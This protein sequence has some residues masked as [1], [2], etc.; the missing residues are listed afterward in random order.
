[1]SG[2]KWGHIGSWVLWILAIGLGARFVLPLAL[3]FVLGGIL[4]L[5]AEPG[6]RLLQ[7]RFHWSRLP[8]VGVCVS[9]TLALTAALVSI[10]GAA[11]VRELSTVARLAP[12]VGKTVAQGLVV[13]EDWLVNLADSAPEEIRPL[14]IQTVL[15][16][17]HS[18]TAL[19]QQ[20]TG[21]IPGAVAGAVGMVSRGTLTAGTGI[22]A[23]FM[24]SARLPKIRDWV[25]KHLPQGWY[26]KIVPGF[27]RV[28]K[29]FSKWLTAQLKL[30]AVNWLVVTAGFLLLRI[31]RSFL[32]GTLV[33][34]VDAVP[35]LGTGT[36]LVP[37]ALVELLQG[38]T[39]QGIGL[40]GIYAAA[41]VVRS[42]LEPRVVGKSLGLDPLISLGAFY[43]GWKLWGVGGMIFA[44]LTVALLKG[45]LDSSRS[46]DSGR[47]TKEKSADF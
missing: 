47:E 8:A 29:A 4:A 21:K 26:D 18:G 31:P 3:P 25:Q 13:L 17:F 40:V 7:S 19:V 34:L 24:I 1:M 38:N 30:V 43:V 12:D 15:D 42:V 10:V 23:G 16:T 33:A 39:A 32:W 14:L 45:L 9:L 20:V 6:V 36:V 37:W 5:G 41:S 27:Y 44:P 28:R 35:V 2:K 11:M 22:L 46:S